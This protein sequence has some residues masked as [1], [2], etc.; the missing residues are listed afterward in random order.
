MTLTVSDTAAAGHAYARAR[1]HARLPP[2]KGRASA[3][4]SD[5][6]PVLVKCAGRTYTLRIDGK[7]A[8]AG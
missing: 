2:L 8:R 5:E 7:P 6:G 1:R 3:V 4:P